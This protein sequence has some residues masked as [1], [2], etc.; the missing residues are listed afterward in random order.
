MAENQLV[1]QWLSAAR[2]S[3]IRPLDEPQF[4]AT[5]ALAEATKWIGESLAELV[6]MVKESEE[7]GDD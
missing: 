1:E 5:M 6:Q 7:A 4:C 3:S 2:S